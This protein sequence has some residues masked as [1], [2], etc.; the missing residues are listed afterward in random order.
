MAVRKNIMRTYK[1]TLDLLTSS[2]IKN[3]FEASKNI[4][5]GDEKKRRVR[6]AIYSD[7]YKIRL[8]GAVRMDYPT[9][10][11]YLGKQAETLVQK[12][13]EEIRSNSYNLDKYPVSFADYVYGKNIPPEAKELAKL[14]AAILKVFAAPD[15]EGLAAAEMQKKIEAGF[16]ELKVNLRTAS[17]LVEFEF[18][19][20][21]YLS[22]FRAEK[23]P[24][25][26]ARKKTYI[27]ICRNDNEVKRH[28][29]DKYEFALL[30]K[31]NAGLSFGQAVTGLMA[32]D[33]DFENE[34]G[35]NFQNWLQKW[36]V[37]GVFD[38]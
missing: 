8:S 27:F 16:E 23:K 25:K 21:K 30:K 24:R 29:L 20:E 6:F 9:F 17:E 7:G 36:L 10:C 14:E 37:N 5:V 4:T 35:K 31:L 18:D 34:M 3:D 38:G 13:A 26:L 28:I 12:F 2:I 19:V 22:E 33:K 1:E 15:S 32:E 11:N